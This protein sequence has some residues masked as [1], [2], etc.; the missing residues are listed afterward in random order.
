MTIATKVDRETEDAFPAPQPGS[1]RWHSAQGG[2]PSTTNCVAVKIWA[3]AIMTTPRMTRTA[4]SAPSLSAG[5]PEESVGTWGS[6]CIAPASPTT[7]TPSTTPKSESSWKRYSFLRR[8]V[9]LKKSRRKNQGAAGHLVDGGS[10]KGEGRY[11]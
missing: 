1:G 9:T 2:D 5:S 11:S 10:H 8:K 6:G 4:A 3:P 7:A